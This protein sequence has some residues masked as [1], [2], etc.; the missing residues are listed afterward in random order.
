[1]S[2]D[3]KIKKISYLERLFFCL[4]FYLLISLVLFAFSYF[5]NQEI[6]IYGIGIPILIFVFA[7]IKYYSW[8]RYYLIEITETNRELCFKLYDKSKIIELNI[9]KKD[10]SLVL[11]KTLSISGLYRL[12]LLSKQ[13][14]IFTQYQ[15]CDW[16]RKH[17]IQLYNELSMYK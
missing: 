4:K 6:N 1:M 10:F 7:V 5:Y 17:I 8:A 13:K 2:I 9:Q 3:I 16:N 12:K 15:I 14:I 11:E